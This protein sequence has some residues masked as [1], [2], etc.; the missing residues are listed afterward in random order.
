MSELTIRKDNNLGG[1]TKLNRITLYIDPEIYAEIEKFAKED[2]R[3]LSQ[4]SALALEAF[5]RDRKKSSEQ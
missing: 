1:K 5:V 2:R 3:T 4:W